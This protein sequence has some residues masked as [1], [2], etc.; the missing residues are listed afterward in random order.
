MV[1]DVCLRVTNFGLFTNIVGNYRVVKHVVDLSLVIVLVTS[2]AGLV[3]E[4]QQ[5]CSPGQ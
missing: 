1:S 4:L 2:S 3:A 5:S